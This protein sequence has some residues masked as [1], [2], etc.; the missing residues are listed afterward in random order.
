MDKQ[1][2]KKEVV[3]IS[4]FEHNWDGYGAEVFTKEIINK[5]NIVIDCFDDNL[6]D[7]CVVPSCVGI[8]F[9][10][11]IAKYDALEISVDGVY[12]E[13]ISYLRIIGEDMKDWVDKKISDLS[14]INELL[15]KFYGEEK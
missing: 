13:E 7:P 11:D 1:K 15:E 9:E 12:G 10:W 8:Q 2:L 14:E 3:E 4:E 6:P 5:A